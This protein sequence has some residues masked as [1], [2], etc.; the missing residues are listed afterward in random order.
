VLPAENINLKNSFGTIVINYVVDG[1]SLKVVKLFR[2]PDPVAEEQ[3]WPE[4]K[5]LFDL[6]STENYSKIII[7]AE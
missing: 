1:N 2:V 4:V 7:K 6:W 5:A 3:L